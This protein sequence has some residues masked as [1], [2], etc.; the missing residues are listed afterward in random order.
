MY[1]PNCGTQNVEE[2]K[3]CTRCG[4]NLSSV[5]QAL[6]GAFRESA[7]SQDLIK[8]LKGYFAGRRRTV[9][10]ATLLG[11]GLLIIIMLAIVANVAPEAAFWIISWMFLWGVIE[12]AVGLSK[13][14]GAG[15]ELRALGYDP[16]SKTLPR[17]SSV[18]L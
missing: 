11:G 14:A 1:C 4:T 13:L 6:T 17:Q 15:A 7:P 18:H 8:P 9:F 10:G 3:F 2:V 12:L 5:S 16:S